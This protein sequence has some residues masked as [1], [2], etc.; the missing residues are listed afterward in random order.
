ML[1][2][3]QAHFGPHGNSPDTGDSDTAEINA[4]NAIKT[5]HFLMRL[6]PEPD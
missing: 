4:I 2:V 6:S 1:A 5:K 3:Q